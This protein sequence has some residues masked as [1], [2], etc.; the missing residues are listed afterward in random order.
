MTNRP[1]VLLCDDAPGYRV[2]LQ[3]V[4]D[5]AGFE[6]AA[7][8]TSW[9]EAERLAAAEPYAAILLDLWLPVFDADAIARVRAACPG[10]VL[11]IVSSLAVDEV[12]ALVADVA[13]IDLVASKRDAPARIAT[14]LRARLDT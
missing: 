11:A 10:A 8:A 1:R 3:T 6:V 4:L 5:A 13:G 7:E 2:L 14:A 12:A 9:G